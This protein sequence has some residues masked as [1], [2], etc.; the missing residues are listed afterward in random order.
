MERSAFMK[1]MCDEVHRQNGEN[2]Y[3]SVVTLEDPKEGE[4]LFH[5]EKKDFQPGNPGHDCYSVAKS[6]T[7]IAVGILFD[8]GLLKLT[9]T[10]GQHL[11][12]YFIEGTDPKWRDVTIHQLMRHRTGARSGVDFDTTNAHLWEDPEWLHTLF[13]EPIVSDPEES[14]VYSDGNYYILGRIIEEIVGVDLELF[15]QREVFVP[16]GCHVNAWS[17]DVNGHTVGGT[18]LYFRTEDLAKIGWLWANEG[19]WGNRRI[20]SKAWSDIFVNYQMDHVSGYGYGVTR[21]ADGVIAAGG[22]YG[23]GVCADLHRRRVV[24]FHCFD[25]HGKTAGLNGFCASLED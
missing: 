7:T 19:V 22:M 15:M 9:D 12:S 3:Y 4:D 25:P 6:I 13:S 5:M 8:R 2:I 1:A 18:G 24:A 14:F 21:L 23:Q 10:L 17:R 16:L 20:Y 11:S